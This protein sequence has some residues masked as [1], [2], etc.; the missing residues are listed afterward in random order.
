M[1]LYFGCRT[2]DEY[3]FENELQEYIE[4]GTLSQLSVAFSRE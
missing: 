2:K 4:N 1:R 3:L